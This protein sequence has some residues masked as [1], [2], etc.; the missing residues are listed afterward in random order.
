MS[1]RP[2]R[3]IL[4]SLVLKYGKPILRLVNSSTVCFSFDAKGD[5]FCKNAQVKRYSNMSINLKKINYRTNKLFLDLS[6]PA[7]VNVTDHPNGSFTCLVWFPLRGSI[8]LGRKEKKGV[9][10]EFLE[11]WGGGVTAFS[12]GH[13]L[14]SRYPHSILKVYSRLA[15]FPSQDPSARIMTPLL[16]LPTKPALAGGVGHFPRRNGKGR[17]VSP[18]PTLSRPPVNRHNQS[19]FL[20]KPIW[21]TN[22]LRYV[23][24]SR[25]GIPC[26]AL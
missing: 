23:C 17:G 20:K 9:G 6:N 1:V 24:E 13:P 15:H 5:S 14:V 7:L 11:S 10:A 2:Q 22:H 21:G 18:G 12:Q 16:T 19:E 26:R 25:A 8:C 3:V 4:F